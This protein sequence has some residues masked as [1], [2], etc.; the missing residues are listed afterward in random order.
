MSPDFGV[1]DGVGMEH[2]DADSEL[3]ELEGGDAGELGDARFG[4]GVG[5]SARSGSGEVAA[6]DDDDARLLVALL[7]G[8]DGVFE[9]ALGGGEVDLDV[10]V[11]RVGF[12]VD[13]FA[14]FEDAGVGDDDVEASVL[15][16][17]FV[18]GSLEGGVVGDIANGSGEALASHVGDD[19]GIDVEADDGGSVVAK[20]F[21]C[22]ATDASAGSGDDGDFI[23]VNLF[24]HDGVIWEELFVIWE[25]L[26]ESGLDFLGALARLWGGLKSAVR[27]FFGF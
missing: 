4:H 27:L 22:G 17:D 15:G 8:G 13:V 5:G 20:T 21:G 24:G 3:G 6:S 23:G 7:E 2:V 19:V 11:P 18:D 16:D 25:N 1:E 9:E 26:G 10:K 14:G 12:G